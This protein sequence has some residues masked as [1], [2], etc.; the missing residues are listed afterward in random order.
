M[1]EIS[2]AVEIVFCTVLQIPVEDRIQPLRDRFLRWTLFR[3]HAPFLRHYPNQN[4]RSVD[5]S[6]RRAL[7]LEIA[8][9]TCNRSLRPRRE[10][11]SRAN[12]KSQFQ[13]LAESV[14]QYFYVRTVYGP[15][16]SRSNVPAS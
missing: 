1:N 9:E 5:K 8:P 14:L 7:T 12:G 11:H 3:C 2:L 13:A 4:P 6:S 15:K 16:L 10:L